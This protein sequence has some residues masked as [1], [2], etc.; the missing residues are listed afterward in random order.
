[1]EAD[2][3][4]SVRFHE[5]LRQQ[6]LDRFRLGVVNL[7]GAPLP[8]MRGSMCDAAAIIEGRTEFGTSLHWMDTGI[9]TGPILAV[10]RFPIEPDDTVYELF[11]Q[12]NSL[13]FQL[14]QETLISI[15]EGNL[16]GISQHT[17]IEQSGIPVK[18][19]Y[20]KEVLKYKRLSAGLSEEELW[21]LTRAFQFP[22]HD[23]AHI[24]TDK[25]KIIL[26][27]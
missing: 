3:G 27:V 9:D 20:A 6:H 5:I 22:G 8:D 17:Y 4:L 16:Q 1:V 11:E 15:V 26:T 21:N 12:S 10:R 13:G 2:I 19:Y 18:T 7:H 24:Q 25:G 23:P 14:I